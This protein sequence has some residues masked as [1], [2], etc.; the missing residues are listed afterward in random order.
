MATEN[1]NIPELTKKDFQVDNPIKWCAG[2]GSYAILN[3]VSNTL[4]KLGVRKEDV[5]FV[6]GI[7]CSSRF[8]YYI[9]TYGFHGLH[10]RAAAIASGVKAANPKLNV[11]Q[12][13]GDGDSMAI[14][15]NHFIHLL[16]R[17]IDIN[18]LLLNNKIYGLTKGQY[19]PTTPRGAKTKTSP[20]GT[21]EDAFKPGELA[22]GSGAHFFA[23]VVDTDQKMMQDAFLQ[24]G[25]HKGAALTEVL[26]NCVI[27]NNKAHLDIT[28]K[29]IKD[30]NTIYLEHGKKM[31]FGKDR[32][33]GLVLDGL[34][35]KAVK[36]GENGITEDDILT[37]DS[38]CED[39]T[40][41]YMLA[42]M[43]RPDM[44]L[45]LGVIRNFQGDCYDQLLEEQVETAKAEA[46][47]KNMDQLL[48]S[49]NI[50]EN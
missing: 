14:G 27:F 33:K 22:I 42:R 24:S 12:I 10:G 7:G 41:H 13:T 18:I 30:D 36:I 44:P 15:G 4:P 1:I 45:A 8:P 9:K 16:R 37:H 3:S 17:N 5:V 35:L 39:T 19:S 21:I 34:K 11:W 31:I 49:G 48:R 40:M 20:D 28:Q 46:Q 2:C 47:I 43:A 25:M 6:S 50:F 38:K 32:D 29:D 26:E 23:R